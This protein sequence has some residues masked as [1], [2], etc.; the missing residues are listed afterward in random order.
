MKIFL[1]ILLL[2]IMISRM[3]EATPIVEIDFDKPKEMTTSEPAE[4]FSPVIVSFAGDCAF[5]SFLLEAY[6]KN[7]AGYYLGNVKHIFTADD[8][9][10]VNLEGA[11]TKQSTTEIKEFSLRG[12][13]KYVEILT[14]SSVEICNLAN[15]HIYDCGE[16]GFK[17]TVNLLK[18]NDIKFCGE[19]Y[20]EIIDVRGMKIGFLGYQAWADTCDLRERLST[21]IKNIQTSG[22]EVVIVEFHWGY[23]LDHVSLPYQTQIAHFTIDSGADIVVGAHPHVMQGIELYNGKVIAYSLGNFCFGANIN[24]RDK[25]T[26]ILQATLTKNA[27]TVS[28]TPHVIPCR[29]SSTNAYN[30]FCPTPVIDAEAEQVLNHLADYSKGYGHTIDFSN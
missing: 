3:S 29:I 24:P 2:M 10:F 30:D 5:D 13:P 16:G 18:A 15:N 26:F 17:D 8:I 21:D 9:T 19:G 11:L 6:W 14:S 28:I 7:G 25:E 12:E 1:R 20:S 27:E 4:E 23:E 22:A